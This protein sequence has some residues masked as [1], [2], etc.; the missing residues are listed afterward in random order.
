MTD[1]RDPSVL[2]FVEAV[3]AKVMSHVRAGRCVF[4][5]GT[6][7]H[8]LVVHAAGCS[9]VPCSNCH[10]NGFSS[11]NR[12]ALCTICRGIGYTPGDEF[13]EAAT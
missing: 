13:W 1:K 7:G 10:G 6:E 2:A 12:P 3:T 9:C 5:E 8:A 4:V 11:G